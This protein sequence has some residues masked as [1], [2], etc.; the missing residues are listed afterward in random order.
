VLSREGY[1]VDEAGGG[2]KALKDIAWDGYDAIV[3]DL[4]MPVV[5]GYDVLRAISQVRPN[6]RCVVVMSA[7]AQRDIDNADPTIVRARLRKP[8]NM[9]ELVSAVRS[10]TE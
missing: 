8:F 1:D 2:E 3:L 6:S 7:A 9:N 5:S 4:M 10:C